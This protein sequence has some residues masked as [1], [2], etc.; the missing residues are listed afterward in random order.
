MGS[1]RQVDRARA[2]RMIGN[3]VGSKDSEILKSNI[4]REEALEAILS[5]LTRLVAMAEARAAR[6][7]QP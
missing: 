1:D 3:M 7:S 6:E 4:R 2:S 5:K